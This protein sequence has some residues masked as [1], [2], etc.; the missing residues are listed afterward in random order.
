MSWLALLDLSAH[1]ATYR[2]TNGQA[3]AQRN[4][5]VTVLRTAFP[6][7]Q[8]TVEDDTAEGDSLSAMMTHHLARSPHGRRRVWQAVRLLVAGLLLYA[9]LAYV[10]APAAWRHYEHH[11]ALETAPKT[12]TTSEGIPGDPLNI[13]LVGTEAE[14]VH[15]LLAAGWT[16]ADPITLRTSLGI[17]ESVLLRRPDPE[18]P[19]SP[20]LLWGRRQDLAFEREAGRSARQRHHARLWHAPEFGVGGRPF[21]IGATTF[22]ISVGLSHRTGQITHHIAPNIDTERDT[23]MGDLQRAGQLVQQY[24]VTGIGATVRGRN[25][26]GDLYYTDGEL[27]VGVL[28]PNN[29]AQAVAPVQLPNPPAVTLK[30][31]GWS[32]LRQQLA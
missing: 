17:A 8:Y 10:V 4:G 16:P 25:G 24:Q 15:A 1:G 7:F 12:T 14:V 26:G 29:E 23:F 13:G 31:R 27:T 28:A 6:G 20:L 9:V 21:W 30:N 5:D 32:W 18:A 2:P 11:P 22:D 19:V 3:L